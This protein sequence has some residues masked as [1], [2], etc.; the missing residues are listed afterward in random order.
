MK[1]GVLNVTVFWQQEVLVEPR[2]HLKN[3]RMKCA[4]VFQVQSLWKEF[5]SLVLLLGFKKDIPPQQPSYTSRPRPCG[6]HSPFP[7]SWSSATLTITASPI[8]GPSSLHVR[9]KGLKGVLLLLTNSLSA[10][11]QDCLQGADQLPCNIFI[12][13]PCVN[14]MQVTYSF[15]VNTLH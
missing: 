15:N 11:T 1:R 2:D 10:D 4:S 5:L 8:A 3:S 12:K 6:S 13:H 7:Q 14:S 9:H